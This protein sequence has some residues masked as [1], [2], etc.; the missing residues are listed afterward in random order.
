MNKLKGILKLYT[1]ELFAK[2]VFTHD[3]PIRATVKFTLKDRMGSK[4]NL[5]VKRI[6]AHCSVVVIITELVV[7]GTPIK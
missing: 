3:V 2:G 1:G 7:S 4:P 6:L 5:S